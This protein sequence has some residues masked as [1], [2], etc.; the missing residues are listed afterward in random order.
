ME[1]KAYPIK[2]LCKVMGVS[3][4]GYYAYKKGL[5]MLKPNQDSALLIAVKALAS[6]TR[7]SY[8]SRRISKALTARGNIVGRYKART[9]MHQAGIECKQRRR[10][11]MTTMSPPTE[12]VADNVLNR[13]FSVSLPNKVWVADITCLWTHEG[14]LYVAAVL[15]LFSRRVIGWAIDTHMKEALISD[16]LSMGLGRRMPEPG[17]MHHSD[18]GCQYTSRDYQCLLKQEGIQV[19]MS[20]KGNCWDNAV[21]ERFFG[22]LKSERTDHKRYLTR[23]EAKADIIDYIEMFYN[24]RRLHST[25]GYRAP[26]EYENINHSLFA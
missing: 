25:L 16:A 2:L 14:W 9:L 17:L 3:R 20:R 15:D 8:G 6:E 21:M 26:L 22:S 1:Q 7:Y 10:Y 11:K 18:R 12:R 19:S 23:E 5:N 4:S 13:K 24:S